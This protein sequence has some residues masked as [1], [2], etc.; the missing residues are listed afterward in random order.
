MGERIPIK[1]VQKL[2][3]ASSVV[4]LFEIE[5]NNTSSVYL[6]KS[7]DSDLGSI[8]MYDYDT[9][10]QKNTYIPIP[11][12]IE[13][14]DIT[15]KGVSARPVLTISNVLADF[16]NAISPLTF[17]DLVGKKLYRRKTLRSSAR[18]CQPRCT[19]NSIKRRILFQK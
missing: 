14:I 16:E 11:L 12:S 17:Q 10:T 15:T 3:Q 18:A 9:N 5:L 13:G 2:E 7:V 19:E 8:E 1:E 6:T 4:E